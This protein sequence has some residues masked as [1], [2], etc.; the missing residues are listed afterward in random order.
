MKKRAAF[1]HKQICVRIL[2]LPLTFRVALTVFLNLSDL[3][4]IMLKMGTGTYRI[5]GSIEQ[6]SV[7]STGSLEDPQYILIITI[8]GHD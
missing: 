4:F 5:T 7:G 1:R 8:S 3:Q 2:I 6:S